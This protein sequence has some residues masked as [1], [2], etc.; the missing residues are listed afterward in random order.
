[1]SDGKTTGHN[2]DIIFGGLGSDWI[3]GG[4]GDDAISGAE[5][6]IVSYTQTEIGVE[7]SGIAET[8]YSHPYNPSDALRFNPTDPDGKFTHPHIANRTGE[9]ALYDENDPL[10]IVLLNADGTLDKTTVIPANGIV[11]TAARQFF[12]DFN[13]NEGVLHAAGTAQQNGQQTV[14]YPAVSD[15]GNDNIFGDDGNDWI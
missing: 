12:L 7:L 2:D 15:D 4:S 9:F 8:D 1:P 13:Q 6:L 11:P 5:A 14:N 10:R 3:H